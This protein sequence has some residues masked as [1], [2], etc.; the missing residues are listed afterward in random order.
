MDDGHHHWLCRRL[1]RVP[2]SD[3]WH[4]AHGMLAG[5]AAAVALQRTARA[6]TLARQVLLL[7]LPRPHG[8]HR[9]AGKN[10]LGYETKS[11]FIIICVVTALL[12]CNGGNKDSALAIWHAV[13][14]GSANITSTAIAK[15]VK[16]HKLW[17]YF[18]IIFL[19]LRRNSS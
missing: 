18:E 8:S 13:L 17:R 12:G 6:A 5:G 14:K 4:G 3:I 19:T 2:Q 1:L 16:N 15:A 9:S 10:H 11:F 7:L